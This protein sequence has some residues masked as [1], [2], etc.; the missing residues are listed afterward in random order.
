MEARPEPFMDY[1]LDYLTLTQEITI[2]D[3]HTRIK[4]RL[5]A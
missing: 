5:E 1:L 3:I 2:P 4:E